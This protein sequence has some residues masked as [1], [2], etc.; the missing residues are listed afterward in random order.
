MSIGMNMCSQC[1]EFMRSKI[2]SA[3]LGMEDGNR[4]LFMSVMRV[5]RK[6]NRMTQGEKL[7]E[8]SNV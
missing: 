6:R 7:E 2:W 8:K 4:I 5:A 3:S 1:L